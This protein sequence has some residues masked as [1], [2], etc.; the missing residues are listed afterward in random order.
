MTPSRPHRRR[1]A[2]LGVLVL[3]LTACSGGSESEPT[4]PSVSDAGGRQVPTQV[5]PDGL[6]VGFPRDEVPVVE[7]EIVSVQEPSEDNPSYSVLI[8]A[9]D[10]P[11]PAVVEQ[12]VG[13]LEDAGWELTTTLEG[14]PPPAQLLTKTG[15]V[16]QQVIL[17]TSFQR[18][19]SALS[20]TVQ[21]SG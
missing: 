3:T 4:P 14:D 13:Q 15:G 16:A 2:A 6:P 9:G 11:R 8:Y 21:V 17:T 20:Y 10:T 19:E 1:A 18:N 12:A 7:G 5:E